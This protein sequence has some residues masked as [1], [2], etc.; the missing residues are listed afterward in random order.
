MSPMEFTAEDILKIEE[1]LQK[2]LPPKR[3]LHTLGVAY[4]SASLAM[5]HGISQRKAL[6]AGLLHDC[7]KA[8]SNEELREKC[9]SLNLSVSEHEMHLPQ[10]L[11]AAYGAYL[12]KE[13]YAVTEE[14]ILLA[15]RY[16]TVGRPAMTKLEQ[17]VFLADYLEPER[18]QVTSPPLDV[19]RKIAFSDLEEAMYLVLKNTIRYMEESKQ[20]TAPETYETFQ[21]YV[22]KRMG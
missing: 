14:E 11:H 18:T 13:E 12:A 7:A 15:I 2:I 8:Y 10:L 9:R 20:E 22:N 6:V 1:K 16:H 4:L 3:Y 5:C 17:I 21:D 19:I